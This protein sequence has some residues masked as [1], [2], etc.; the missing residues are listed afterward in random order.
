M[1]DI[2][3]I[4][5]CENPITVASLDIKDDNC[6]DSIAETAPKIDPIHTVSNTHILTEAKARFNFFAPMFWLM[7]GIT[8]I[9]GALQILYK[10]PSKVLAIETPV[11]AAGPNVFTAEEITTFAIE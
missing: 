5:C 6:G 2:I 10:I 8:A 4:F 3:I 7:Y 9:D 11:D 1:L